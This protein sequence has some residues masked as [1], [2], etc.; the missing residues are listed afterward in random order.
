SCRRYQGRCSQPERLGGDRAR[1]NHARSCTHA[2][3]NCGWLRWP[4]R[5]TIEHAKLVP[6]D[7]VPP[8]AKNRRRGISRRRSWPVRTR[9]GDRI[10]IG[11]D[12]SGERDVRRPP[13]GDT[14]FGAAE[15]RRHALVATRQN[16]C[17][18][19]GPEARGKRR[20]SMGHAKIESREHVD[21][22]DEQQ[23]RLAACPRL[24]RDEVTHGLVIRAT[25]ETVHRLGWIR[26]HASLVEVRDRIV[27]RRVDFF[28]GPEW[29]RARR[30]F[31]S[32]SMLS[33]S[34]RAK[35]ASVVIF[36]ALSLPGMT[37]TGYP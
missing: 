33:A 29:Y 1:S 2:I 32:T 17:Q 10:A 30:H 34:A 37:T 8:I 22:G 14:A 24:E 5:P 28:R 6:R 26:E 25:A 21:A 19:P 7:S 12:Q 31:H 20:R 23:K 11:A 35:S 16:Q 36:I 3:Y 18:R 27:Q 4:E 13:N 15:L 9:R